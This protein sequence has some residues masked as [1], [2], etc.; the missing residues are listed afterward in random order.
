MHG[1]L[2]LRTSDSGRKAQVLTGHPSIASRMV[3]Y[4]SHARARMAERAITES[5]VEE[6]LARPLEVV[7][8]RYGRRAACM[9]TGS[10]K[11]LV[12][13]FEGRKTL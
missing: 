1:E 8:T 4:A 10:G 13:I 11:Y 9:R 5:E 2:P 6:T 7:S 3:R 12:V